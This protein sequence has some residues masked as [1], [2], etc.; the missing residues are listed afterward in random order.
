MLATLKFLS[1]PRL[2]PHLDEH[3]MSAKLQAY[4]AVMV[5]GQTGA[6][7]GL[8]IALAASFQEIPKTQI[9]LIVSLVTGMIALA[10]VTLATHR[11]QPPIIQTSRHMH[12]CALLGASLAA[13]LW[14]ALGMR[15]TLVLILLGMCIRW[16]LYGSETLQLHRADQNKEPRPSAATHTRRWVT[17]VTGALI[18]LIV[19]GGASPHIW[20][21]IS[22]G[23]TFFCQWTIASE[24]CH[25]SA[26]LID[27]HRH[28]SASERH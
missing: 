16:Y 11:N 18:P 20:L 13:A 24:R 28:P 27:A 1:L 8:I 17:L 15:H 5:I 6:G 22:F 25:Q 10:F 26:C 12:G 3:A 14:Q 9:L 19:L 2:P 21:W 7:L 4:A 23:L